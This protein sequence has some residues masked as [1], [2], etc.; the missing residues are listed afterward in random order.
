MN[1]EKDD[2]Y[3]AGRLIQYALQPAAVPERNEEYSRLIEMYLDR[4]EF[5]ATVR[6]IADGLGLLIVGE[7]RRNWSLIVAAKPDSV[8]SMRAQDYRASHSYKAERRLLDGLIHVA[9]AAAVFPRDA[10]LFDYSR[11]GRNP[12]TV[13]EIEEMLRQITNQLEE[14]N[15]NNPDP[16][17]GA[18]DL[19]E[20]W[21]IY[22]KYPETKETTNNRNA[23]WTTR[24]MIEKALEY[25]CERRCFKKEDKSYKPLPRYQVLVQEYAASQ[26]HQAVKR[27]LVQTEK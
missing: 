19:H 16:P 2:S 27:Y 23:T 9:I 5:G 11:K 15:K 7:V 4:A 24:S 21:R 26:I 13:D 22:K 8:F 14:E 10:D 3:Y 12:V 6:N 1:E 20:A 17:A 18:E 25:L